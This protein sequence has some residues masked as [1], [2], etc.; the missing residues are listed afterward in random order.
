M[1]SSS[2]NK[3]PK[4][5]WSNTTACGLLGLGLL[6]S[7]SACERSSQ[8]APGNPSI[9]DTAL[10]DSVENQNAAAPTPAAVVDAMLQQAIAAEMNWAVIGVVCQFVDVIDEGSRSQTVELRAQ[11]MHTSSDLIASPFHVEQHL[12]GPGQPVPGKPYVFVVAGPSV[13]EGVDWQIV[14]WVASSDEGLVA[15]ADTWRRAIDSAL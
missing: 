7:L 14:H 6:S 5:L 2:P 8:S 9:G 12:K 11:V 1:Q 13:G 10:S 4:P 15:D 3:H